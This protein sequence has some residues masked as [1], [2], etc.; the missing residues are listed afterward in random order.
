MIRVKLGNLIHRKLTDNFSL[1]LSICVQQCR[2][3]LGP[4][5]WL[6]GRLLALLN[7]SEVNKITHS[8]RKRHGAKMREKTISHVRKF[9]PEETLLCRA[10]DWL[11]YA[12]QK[13][14]VPRF[15]C[16]RAH[17]KHAHTAHA[18]IE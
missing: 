8:F 2:W 18:C 17:N 14:S 11:A 16:A 6:A 1:Q 4:D 12:E 5:H 15:L 9:E 10:D 3:S 13:A 7:D